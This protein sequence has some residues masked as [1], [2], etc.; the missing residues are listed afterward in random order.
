VPTIAESGYPDFKVENLA[1]MLAPAGISEPIAQRLELEVQVAV[2]QPDV[3]E[4]LRAMDTT[5]LGLVGPEV[6]ARIKADREAWA[7]V[8]AAANMRLE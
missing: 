8:V 5:A 3:I 1:V 4:R 6:A 7:K 2:R